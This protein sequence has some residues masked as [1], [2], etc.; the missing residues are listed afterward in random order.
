MNKKNILLGLMII[1]YIIQI[2]YI[3]LNYSKNHSVSNVINSKICNSIIFYSMIIMGYFTL[4]Y[5][6]ERKDFMSMLFIVSLLIGIFGVITIYEDKIRHYFFAGLVLISMLGFMF[7]NSRII[8]C[9]LLNLLLYIEIILFLTILIN[10]K[11]NIFYSEIFFI[12]NFAIYYL[13]LH[14]LK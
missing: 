1:S 10:I 4:L 6:L 12:L 7:Y 9:K 13:Y 14:F 2:S 3:Y 8:N 11:K 5:E